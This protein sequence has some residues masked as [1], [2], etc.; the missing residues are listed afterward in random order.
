L[1]Y[2]DKDI[3]IILDTKRA[4]V[5]KK[6]VEMITHD[7][8]VIPIYNTVAVFAMQENIDFKPTQK[9]QMDVVFVKDITLR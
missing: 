7:V 9:Y 3:T 1:S 2:P 5:I 6:A 8:A 4:Q